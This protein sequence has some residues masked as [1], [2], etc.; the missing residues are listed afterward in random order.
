LNPPNVI[1]VPYQAGVPVTIHASLSAIAGAADVS[2][3]GDMDA[4]LDVLV[5]SAVRSERSDDAI[6]RGASWVIVPEPTAFG[7]A[8]LGL[9][10]ICGL[11]RYWP[12][13]VSADH[14]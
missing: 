7:F 14:H 12:R 4:S 2:F 1:Y 10:L 9:G 11:R 5:S 3:S 13:R 6:I 8:A